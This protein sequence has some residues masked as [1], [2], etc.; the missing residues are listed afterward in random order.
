MRQKSR[1][2]ICIEQSTTEWANSISRPIV[3]KIDPNF[4]RTVL[5]NTK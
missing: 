1:I 5:V 3:R 4:A 2:I